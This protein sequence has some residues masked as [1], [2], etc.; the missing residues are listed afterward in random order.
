MSLLS[1]SRNTLQE[2]TELVRP[3]ATA[4]PEIIAASTMLRPCLPWG[5]FR[6]GDTVLIA[7]SSSLIFLAVAHATQHGLWCGVVALPHLNFA[8]GE[9]V[10][11][12]LARVVLVQEPSC[13][14][15]E[16]TAALI[17]ALDIVVVGFT[18]SLTDT[19]LR[20]LS[21]R[22]RQRRKVLLVVSQS[23]PPKLSGVALSLTAIHHHWHGVSDGFGYLTEHR[24]DVSVTGHGR[25]DKQQQHTI[26]IP[27]VKPFS[28]TLSVI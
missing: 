8:A 9:A 2:L 24:I 20:K 14:L 13:H 1:A 15:A 21:A 26:T 4:I 10:G 27:A 17:D 3:A 25:A 22:A 11:V 23:T 6:R 19:M 12:E 16:V 28:T 7:G 5:G 18:P